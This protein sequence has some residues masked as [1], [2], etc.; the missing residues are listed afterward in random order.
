MLF[1]VI[2]IAVGVLVGLVAFATIESWLPAVLFVG[3]ILAQIV[4]GLLVGP[5]LGLSSSGML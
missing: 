3:A 4:L 5:V 2:V 1:W